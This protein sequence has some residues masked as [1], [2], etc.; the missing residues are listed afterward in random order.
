M[1]EAQPHGMLEQLLKLRQ[2]KQQALNS[3]FLPSFL[4]A[5]Q[6]IRES[7]WKV[8]DCP[9]D[10]QDRRIEITGP[11]EPKMMINALN[12]DAKVFMADL[13][14]SLSPSWQNILEGHK[15]LKDAVRHELNFF[16]AKKS[17][18]YS[19][20][21]EIATLIVRPRGLHLQEKNMR[22]SSTTMSA[23]F[24]DFGL[25]MYH[26]AKERLERGT[27]PYFYL[28]KIESHLEARLWKEVIEFTEERLGIPKGSVRVT[29]LIET[30]HAAFEMEEMLFELK[31]YASGFCQTV[32]K[33]LCLYLL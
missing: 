17:K 32:S 10:L 6:H 23:S 16:D 28:P 20:N 2:E 5:T 21:D 4:P 13:E 33:S 18:S 15:A 12:S 9:A 26:N 8:A 29:M 1:M 14:D 27:A 7:D 3:G 25:Y 19:L 24:F 31:E 11:A 22:V 30:I